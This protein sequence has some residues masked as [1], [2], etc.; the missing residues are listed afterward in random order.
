MDFIAPNVYIQFLTQCQNFPMWDTHKQDGRQLLEFVAYL[1][2]NEISLHNL[3][4]QPWSQIFGFDQL[5]RL[6]EWE[7][8][9][10]QALE[11]QEKKTN[12]NKLQCV[13]AWA[14]VHPKSRQPSSWSCFQLPLWRPSLSGWSICISVGP[15]LSSLLKLCLLHFLEMVISS[16]LSKAGTSGL[17]HH[18]PKFL[19]QVFGLEPI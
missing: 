18:V 10:R 4:L 12:Q 13:C 15:P 16:H 1:N 8:V 9:E 2:W 3:N 14:Y 5:Q 7:R 19:S 11:P 17:C 6:T